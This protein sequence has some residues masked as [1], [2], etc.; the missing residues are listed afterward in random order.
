MEFPGEE[1]QKLPLVPTLGL[2]SNDVKGTK[3]QESE[4]SVKDEV[5]T[6]ESSCDENASAKGEEKGSHDNKQQEEMG[7]KENGTVEEM[8]IED[9]IGSSELKES[10]DSK[11]PRLTLTLSKE[12]SANNDYSITNGP[13][14]ELE[15][16]EEK[17][18]RKKH[19]K[20]KCLSMPRSYA[21]KL[22]EIQSSMYKLTSKFPARPLQLDQQRK[23]VQSLS[24]YAEV[25]AKSPPYSAPV[26]GTFHHLSLKGKGSAYRRRYM[27]SGSATET[28][29]RLTRKKRNETEETGQIAAGEDEKKRVR[30]HLTENN[31]WS[32][33]DDYRLLVNITQVNRH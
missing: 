33:S 14:L 17:K 30:S 8:E 19:K 3:S 2:V 26:G 22:V 7:A 4:L 32:P 21:A 15:V 13:D 20:K 24:S 25:P 6:K 18:K 27:S 29:R 12:T 1:V 10:D 11:R 16:A 9:I 28:R 31:V 23:R 5:L